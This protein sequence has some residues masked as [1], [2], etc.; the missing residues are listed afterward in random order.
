MKN[1]L[2]DRPYIAGDEYTVPDM[3]CYP[4]AVRC[5]AL[6]QNIVEF[7]YFRRWLEELGQ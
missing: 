3:A 2:Y 6:G 7:P 4:W 5:M 1:R